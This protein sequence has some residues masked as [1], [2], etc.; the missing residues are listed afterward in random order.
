[1]HAAVVMLMKPGGEQPVQIIQRLH[2]AG[3]LDLD[4]ELLAHA[5]VPALYFAPPLRF[6]GP[7]VHQCDVEHR[8]R[9]RQLWEAY[10]EPLSQSTFR[11]CRGF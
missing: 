8:R 7:A 10:A 5:V 9:P 6:A 3:S 4:Q 2:P 1:M 11:G